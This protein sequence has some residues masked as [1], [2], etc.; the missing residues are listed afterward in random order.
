M[1]AL[2]HFNVRW[3]EGKYSQHCFSETGHVTRLYVCGQAPHGE[4]RE[5][6]TSLPEHERV[7]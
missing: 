5:D 2:T 4:G 7:A 1:L 3:L 6:R